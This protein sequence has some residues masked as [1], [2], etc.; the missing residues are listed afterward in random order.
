MDIK[1]K[2]AVVTGASRGIG[3]ATALLLAKGGCSVVVNYSQ[4]EPEAKETAEQIR[5]AG[6]DVICVQGDVADDQA[7]RQ[8]MKTAVEEFGRLDILINN[9][10]TTQFIPHSDMEKV[11]K[12]LW[13]RIFGVNVRGAF[14]CARAARPYLE[15]AGEGE[16]INISSIAGITGEG[17]S[18]PYAASKAAMM[19]MTLS[20]ARALAPKIRVNSVAP[21]FIE[22]DW[23]RRGLG[24]NYET[25]KQAYENKSILKRICQPEDVAKAILSIITGSD[26]VTGQTFVCDGGYLVASRL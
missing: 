16:I 8:L 3:R 6:A 10:A 24:A 21:G 25:V 14:Q 7:C 22:G 5:K 1:G 2:V 15:E 26:M 4:A 13:D 19:T 9:A 23:T 20:L 12:E 11:H 18:I 17:S